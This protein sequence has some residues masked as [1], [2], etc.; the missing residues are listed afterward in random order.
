[1]RHAVRIR[2]DLFPA[3]AVLC[4]ALPA[5]AA[6]DE[7]KRAEHLFEQLKYPAAVE[8]LD[9]ARAAWG[10]DRPTLLRIVEL[11]AVCAGLLNHPARAARLFE[12]LL[13]LDPALSPREDWPPRVRTPYFEAKA[14]VAEHGSVSFTPSAETSGAGPPRVSLEH[15]E[16]GLARR[17]RF[18]VRA[19]GTGK[20]QAHDQDVQGANVAQDT[21]G[22]RLEWWAELLGERD[23]VLAVVA[24]PD[25]PLSAT[26]EPTAPG[27]APPAAPAA[28]TV[29][30]SALPQAVVTTDAEPRYRPGAY[31]AFAAGAV[32]LGVGAFFTGRWLDERSQL[33]HLTTDSSGRVTN[34]T[35]VQAFALDSS[36]KSDA[37]AADVL[38]GA[39]AALVATGFTLFWVGRVAVTPAP[40]G[41]AVAGALP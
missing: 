12:S 17:V 36:R 8:A 16:L 39:G 10:N 35:Q 6:P 1:M 5:A 22:G 19:P 2:G 13:A 32:S 41:V 9:A 4:V 20:W 11:Q 15:D 18:H 30:P 21:T 34:L 7:L 33:T 38:L 23:A 40:G 37:A 24:S 3:I 31:A 26:S 27:V 29:P 25:A 28:A 14:W